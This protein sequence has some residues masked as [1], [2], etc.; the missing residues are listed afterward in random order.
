MEDFPSTVI[1]QR[2]PTIIFHPA[3]ET[4]D[5]ET[6][7][8]GVSVHSSDWFTGSDTQSEMG[9]EERPRGSKGKAGSSA[10]VLLD[11]QEEKN[12]PV[13]DE[14][15]CRICFGG[16]EEEAEMGKLIRP[17]RCRG[18]MRVSDLYFYEKVVI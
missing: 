15:Q 16:V 14:K 5:H 6:D 3:S 11:E 2:R 9:F 8:D 13:L 12:E 4:G 10:Q 17:C 18:S 1:R 7:T